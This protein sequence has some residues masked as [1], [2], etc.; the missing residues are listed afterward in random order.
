M[1]STEL[2]RVAVSFLKERGLSE[3]RSC[4]LAGVSRSGPRYQAHPRDDSDSVVRLSEIAR[5]HKRYGYRRAPA[6][7]GPDT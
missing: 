4:L 6:L 5:R 7:L 1:V 2:R 3:P